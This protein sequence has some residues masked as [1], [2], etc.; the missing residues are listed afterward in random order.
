MRLLKRNADSAGKNVVLI[1]NEAALLPLA[2]AAGLHVAKNLQSRPE[3]P[4][5][6]DG[7]PPQDEPEEDLQDD[8]AE[9]AA[10]EEEGLRKV[11]YKRPIGSL[12]ATK[13]EPESITLDDDEDGAD[14]DALP[15]AATSKASKKKGLKVPDFDRF[16]MLII[17]GGIGLF[18]FIVFLIFAI[19]VLP[20]ATIAI[21][22]T[23][24]PVSVNIDLKASGDAKQLDL[25]NKV[26]PSVFKTS[27]Q[28]ANQQVNAT[29][30]KNL[31]EKA[32][33]SVTMTA[34]KCSGNPFDTPSSVP[35]GTGMSA[36]GLT[37]I[38]QQA[39]SFHGTGTSNNCFTYTAD[40]TTQITSQDAGDKYNVS[41]ASFS[42]AGRSD[43]S[44]SGSTSGGT[45]KNVTIL[46]Q[47]D[48][49]GA[50]A[51]ISSEDSDD[52][53]KDF[54]KDLED[55][56]YYVFTSTLK[57]GDAKLSS[58]PSV[59]QEAEN[60][61]V[62]V[63][64]T[65][66]VLAVK[67]DDLEKAVTDAAKNQFDKKKQELADQDILS[68]LSVNVQNQKKADATLEIS[69][70]ATAIPI[71]DQNSIKEQAKGQ[72]PSTIQNFIESYPGVEKVDVHLS[73]FWVSKAPNKTG[74]ISITLEQDQ[75]NK[76][77][78]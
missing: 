34:K 22:T 14:S 76:K 68:D 27:D 50:K 47:Q 65:Y 39:T 31:G 75:D 30:Q 41:N 2:G 5:G 55:D 26:I 53:S 33:G 21:K 15:A 7:S 78:Q 9:E 19:W 10:D 38:T 17:F 66:S 46:T 29:G 44:A 49:D 45:D 71:I 58:S 40:S 69:K 25:K 6:P 36:N 12:A 74:K 13:E 54:Q 57:V 3:V 72:K 60:A 20:K 23:S 4:E 52:F 70:E 18:A 43:V 64:I 28:T 16:R 51:K 62:Q 56:G 48:V 42:V 8:A 24:T 59:G 63:K 32:T 67:K 73:P 11:D 61:N 77:E 37:F 1:T 35:A